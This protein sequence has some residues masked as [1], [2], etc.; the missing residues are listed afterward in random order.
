MHSGRNIRALLILALMPTALPIEF[1][2]KDAD[3]YTFK[4][5]RPQM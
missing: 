2:L 1:Y 3:I 5:G 4:A